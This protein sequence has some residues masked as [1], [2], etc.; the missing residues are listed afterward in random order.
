MKDKLAEVEAAR[1][2]HGLEEERSP[3]E[4]S[5]EQKIVVNNLRA[6][7]HGYCGV[8]IYDE[9]QE[10]IQTGKETCLIVTHHHQFP[11]NRQLQLVDGQLLSA[12]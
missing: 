11:H 8:V 5:Y 6:Y 2:R 1:A 4:L 10:V 3:E 7:L 12:E 9:P